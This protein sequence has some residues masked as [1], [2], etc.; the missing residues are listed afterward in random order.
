MKLT[1]N[2]K[3]KINVS[4]SHTYK[5]LISLEIN[6]T[7][8]RFVTLDCP[9]TAPEF[10]E[11][12]YGQIRM[13]EDGQHWSIDAR[14]VSI[15]QSFKWN[16][17]WDRFYFSDQ[18]TS[19]LEVEAVFD[20][21]QKQA[22][23]S[24][25]IA[26]ADVG[27]YFSSNMPSWYI[28]TGLGDRGQVNLALGSSFAHGLVEGKDYYTFMQALGRPAGS[29]WPLGHIPSNS[30]EV[31]FQRGKRFPSWCYGNA[32]CAYSCLSPNQPSTI[33]VIK[34][35]RPAPE[36]CAYFKKNDGTTIGKDC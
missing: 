34:K 16:T 5:K 10:W 32:F 15:Y 6:N 8:D 20:D 18:H 31:R 35:G 2:G 23:V 30:Y 25:T 11:P 26:G 36:E 7:L 27:L 22:W 24:G 9:N 19:T 13:W 12:S 21:R 3:V 1:I 29:P 14:L 33:T 4:I 28:D 17:Y